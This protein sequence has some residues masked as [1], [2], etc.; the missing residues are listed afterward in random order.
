MN[1]KSGATFY[2]QRRHTSMS[3]V[4]GKGCKFLITNIHLTRLFA[5]RTL[6]F[7]FQDW[8]LT[9]GV[10]EPNAMIC[11]KVSRMGDERGL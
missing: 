3:M 10:G 5:K 9:W 2:E 6:S 4:E 8:E 1:F 11:G 7:R